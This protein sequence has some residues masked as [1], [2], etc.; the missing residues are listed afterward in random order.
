V[1]ALPVTPVSAPGDAVAEAPRGADDH[2]VDRPRRHVLHEQLAGDDATLVDPNR[3]P[4]AS[5][6]ELMVVARFRSHGAARG[7]ELAAGL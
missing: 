4:L 6:C 2:F 1:G 3:T 7:N 5:K